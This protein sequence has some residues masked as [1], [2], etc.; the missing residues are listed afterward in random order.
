MPPR[1]RCLFSGFPFA[2][3]FAQGRGVALRI[4]RPIK[5]CRAALVGRH[6]TA[7][8]FFSCIVGR[9]VNEFAGIEIL[10]HVAQHVLRFGFAP[11]EFSSG[12]A[13]PLLFRINFCLVFLAHI[14]KFVFEHINLGLRCGHFFAQGDLIFIRQRE[15]LGAGIALE[16]MDIMLTPRPRRAIGCFFALGFVGTKVGWL[17]GAG[18]NATKERVA[19]VQTVSVVREISRGQVSRITVAIFHSG[20]FAVLSNGMDSQGDGYGGLRGRL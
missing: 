1:L 4:R 18:Q 15:S 13:Q 12:L 20:R 8:D 10:I 16:P 3:V 9:D 11:A 7:H 19:D 17:N 5:Q 6:G 14:G 2:G